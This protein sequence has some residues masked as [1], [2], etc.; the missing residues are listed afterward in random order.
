M[1]DV[2]EWEAVA[3]DAVGLHRF[4]CSDPVEA[5]VKHELCHVRLVTV[6]LRHRERGQVAPA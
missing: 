1:S 6:L 4:D 5:A 3:V 2:P